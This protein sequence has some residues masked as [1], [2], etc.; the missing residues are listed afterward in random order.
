MRV[1]NVILLFTEIRVSCFAVTGGGGGGCLHL[2]QETTPD[3][4]ALLLLTEHSAVQEEDSSA[5]ATAGIHA[6]TGVHAFTAE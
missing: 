1:N 6:G 2:P 5:G 3:N 4:D